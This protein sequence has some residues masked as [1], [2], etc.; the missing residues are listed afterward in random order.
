LTA[1]GLTNKQIARQISVSYS[2]VKSHLAS[3]F[4]KLG[5]ASR[6]QIVLYAAQS[7]LVSGERSGA[8]SEQA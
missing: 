3:I 6:T 5:V 4:T 2:T 7:S 8:H 1:Q